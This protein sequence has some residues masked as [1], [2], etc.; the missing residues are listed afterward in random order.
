[1]ANQL[2]I[3]N[4][5]TIDALP[6]VVWDALTNPEQTKQYMYG[7]E[8]VTDWN[9]GS[10][11]LWRGTHEGQEMV[12]VKGYVVAIEPEKFLSYTTIDP[13]ST[14]DDTSENYL[15]VTYDLAVEQGQTVLTVT[16][17]DYTTVAEGARRYQEAVAEGGWA[18]ILLA[19]KTVIE[20]P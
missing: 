14:I 10:P 8:A 5:I 13:N 7:C 15:T 2:V 17:G 20:Q 9:V 3:Q 18:S 4:S 1:M 16:Q 6:A 19:I 11:L 12:F